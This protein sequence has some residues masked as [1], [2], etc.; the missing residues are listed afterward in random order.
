MYWDELQTRSLHSTPP[1]TLSA[2]N[3]C[4]KK[5]QLINIIAPKTYR[6][7]SFIYKRVYKCNQQIK[8]EV[9]N[10]LLNTNRCLKKAGQV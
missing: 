4:E 5:N 8:K 6:H 3:I 10:S 1:I 2:V 9:K 7:A